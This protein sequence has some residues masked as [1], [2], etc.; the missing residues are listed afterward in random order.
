[1]IVGCLGIVIAA[2]LSTRITVDGRAHLLLHSDA[3]CHY[4]HLVLYT[5]WL[6]WYLIT[7]TLSVQ[8]TLYSLTPSLATDADPRSA[9]IA[10]PHGSCSVSIWA[11]YDIYDDQH[12]GHH[13]AQLAAVGSGLWTFDLIAHVC[14][15]AA[16]ESGQLELQRLFETHDAVAVQTRA[17]C[18]R[19]NN[20]TVAASS[21]SVSVSDDG[22]H[23]HRM[24][25]CCT[26]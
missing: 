8:C 1:M 19:N 6:V 23:L 13:V 20:S 25:R 21:F 2:S 16:V 5:L 4:R 9:L 10:L 12:S 22:G 11:E 3:Y 18:T 24:T 14:V 15:A 7:F 26:F 17:V